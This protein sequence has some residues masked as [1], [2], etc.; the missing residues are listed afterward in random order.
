[1]SPTIRLFE[2]A[3]FKMY[4]YLQGDN[5]VKEDLDRLV[6]YMKVNGL[7]EQFFSYLESLY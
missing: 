5:S 7:K 1:M 4:K 6:N 3:I 2:T